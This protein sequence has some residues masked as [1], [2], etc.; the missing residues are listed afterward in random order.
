MFF[1]PNIINPDQ[2]TW[3]AKVVNKTVFY[4]NE[5]VKQ[6]TSEGSILKITE[7]NALINAFLGK[8]GTNLSEGIFFLSDYFS[9]VTEISG[10]FTEKIDKFD[11]NRDLY[12]LTPSYSNY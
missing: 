6:I 10:V 5:V 1:T 9:V 4:I 8:I 12:G 2:N 7:C 3:K 11:V